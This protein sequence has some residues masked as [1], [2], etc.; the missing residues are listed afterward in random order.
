MAAFRTSCA[1]WVLILSFLS[2]VNFS[3]PLVVNPGAIPAPKVLC[4]G[5][6]LYDCISLPSAAGWGLE[7][8]VAEGA[9]KPYPGGAPANVAW[10]LAKL[11][12]STA[13][14]GVVG[15]DDDGKALLAEF[16]AAGVDA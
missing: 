2:N 15:D 11:G 7:K 16:V 4:H 1:H 13:F 9:W 3:L 14:A 5:E 8:M 10:G 6:V 12:A